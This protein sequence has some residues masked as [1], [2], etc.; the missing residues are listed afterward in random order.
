MSQPLSYI[1]I[2]RENLVHNVKQ[3]RGLIS[4]KT[5]IAGVIKAN[6][7]GHGQNEVAEAILPYVDYFIVNHVD[8]L[9]LLRKLTKKQ[10]FVFGYVQEA[11][12]AHASKLGCVIGVFSLEQ[13]R[14]IDAISAKKKTIQ[15][16][17]LAIDAHL[18]RE[19]VMVGE[20][21]TALLE[22]K[23]LKHIRMTGMYAHFANIEDTTNLSFAK[24]QIQTF[25]KALRIAKK[26]GYTKLQTHI[27]ATSGVLAYE[28]KK[29]IHAIA[30]IG[31]GLYG[32][33][34]SE[35]LEFLYEKKKFKLRPVLSWKTHVALVKMLP[36]GHTV[37][38]G[39]TY[40]TRRLT[41]IALIPQGY[42]D[43][44]PRSLSNKGM[45]LIGGKRCKIIGRVAMNMFVVDVTHVPQVKI[46]DEVVIIGQ[47]GDE[48]ITSEQFAETIDTINYEVTTRISPLLKRILI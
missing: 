36:P 1:E 27:S 24:K 26:M 10:T 39:L 20:L 44:L 12:I 17:H 31:I 5:K 13:A 32:M 19:G 9:E 47:Q 41:K 48:Q 14:A 42:S 6:A 16:I 18:G 46:E 30:R 45:V 21:H 34:P 35:H 43:G 4:K 2:S 40:M 29:G 11:D 15:E 25:D 23:K 38:Y 37:G 22:L 8:E 3:F 28:Q 7:Y 33:W